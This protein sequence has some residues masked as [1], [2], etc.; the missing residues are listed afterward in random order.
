MIKEVT[1]S[2]KPAQKQTTQKGDNSAVP[3]EDVVVGYDKGRPSEV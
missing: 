1:C 3:A 2:K